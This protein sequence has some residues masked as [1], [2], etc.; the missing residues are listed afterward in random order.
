MLLQHEIQPPHRRG[1][2]ILRRPPLRTATKTFHAAAIESSGASP[3]QTGKMPAQRG[4]RRFSAERTEAL[5]V[6]D[7]LQYSQDVPSEIERPDAAI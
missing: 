3:W 2:I 6:H 4:R 1:E 7:A 5:A